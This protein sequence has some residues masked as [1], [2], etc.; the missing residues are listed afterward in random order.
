MR[1]PQDGPEVAAVDGPEE[2]KESESPVEVATGVGDRLFFRQPMRSVHR[3]PRAADGNPL[4]SAAG[5]GTG[6]DKALLLVDRLASPLHLAPLLST[7]FDE[8][9]VSRNRGREKGSHAPYPR[10]ITAIQSIMSGSDELF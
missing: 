2:G 5:A 8:P 9:L 6:A 3:R 7:L 4:A 1:V 10:P